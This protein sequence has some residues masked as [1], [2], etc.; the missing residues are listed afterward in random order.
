MNTW[1]R[2]SK[3]VA[4]V[5]TTLRLPSPFSL[6]ELTVPMFAPCGTFPPEPEVSTSSP[7][8][9]AAPEA[10]PERYRRSP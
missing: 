1:T 9:I 7:G 4:G 3:S 6:T 2:L 10:K 5:T 8:S